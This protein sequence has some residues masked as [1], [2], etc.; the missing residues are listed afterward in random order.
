MPWHLT[1]GTFWKAW[2]VLPTIRVRE[3]HIPRSHVM[4]GL[5]GAMA[6][7]DLSQFHRVFVC[8][9][10]FAGHIPSTHVLQ[11]HPE[12]SQFFLLQS[13]LWILQFSFFTLVFFMSFQCPIPWRKSPIVQWICFLTLR[14]IGSCK[15]RGIH[16]SAWWQQCAD[17]VG[18][19]PALRWLKVWQWYAMIL[20]YSSQESSQENEMLNAKH[21][22]KSCLPMDAS[23]CDH[24]RLVVVLNWLVVSTPFFP[25]REPPIIPSKNNKRKI[26]YTWMHMGLGNKDDN[27]E[28]CCS[29]GWRSL[30][31]ISLSD[32][33]IF[34]WLSL[35]WYHWNWKVSEH[36][37]TVSRIREGFQSIAVL[38][39]GSSSFLMSDQGLHS[40]ASNASWS[41]SRLSSMLFQPSSSLIEG[42]QLAMLGFPKC[43]YGTCCWDWYCLCWGTSWTFPIPS[44]SPSKMLWHTWHT[45]FGP[46]ARPQ[47]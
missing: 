43:I 35:F 11:K 10:T 32:W 7:T 25:P 16:G 41:G 15:G 38:S 3:K 23:S 27:I 1:A 24:E 29:I 6:N 9:A 21:R 8:I 31:C 13:R 40:V 4:F 17:Q 12:F 14:P 44:A 42:S 30:K 22:V 47:L 26:S 39:R 5:P 46:P 37:M 33:L 2:D 28:W 18:Y 20:P 45:L 19:H 36:S 34:C